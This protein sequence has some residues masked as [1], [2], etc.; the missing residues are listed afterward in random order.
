M[1]TIA[2]IA[3]A[4]FVIWGITKDSSISKASKKKCKYCHSTIP[5]RANVCPVCRRTVGGAGSFSE[6]AKDIGSRLTGGMFGFLLK[7]IL[8]LTIVTLVYVFF[9]DGK[10]NL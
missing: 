5:L 10:I 8:L 7:A 2:A 3:V 6:E 9:I 4:V 1:E